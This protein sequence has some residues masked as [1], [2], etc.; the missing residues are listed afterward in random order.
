MKKTLL[1]CLLLFSFIP[2]SYSHMEHYNRYNKL[3][4]EVLRNGEVIGY[5]FYFFK[6]NGKETVVTN[7]IKFV[8]KLLGKT[9]F[10]VEGY[11]EEKYLGDQLTSYNSKTLQN[12]KKKYVNLI[13]NKEDNNFDIKGSSYTGKA[14]IDNVIGGWWNHKILQASSQISPISGSVKEQ[15]V[16]FINKEKI[17]QYGKVYEVDRFRLNS[18]DSSLHKDK[19]LDFDIWYSHKIGKIIRVSYSRMGIWEYRLKNFE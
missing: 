11:G 10:K 3:E 13:I 7:Q 2:N 16:T 1:I 12:N 8:V 17:E 4:M 6:R 9:V 19:K 14:S 15:V 5:N 18:K